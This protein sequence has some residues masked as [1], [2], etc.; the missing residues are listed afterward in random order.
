MKRLYPSARLFFWLATV[1]LMVGI[2][3]L[4]LLCA[5]I[6]LYWVAAV[7]WVCDDHRHKQLLFWS[8]ATFGVFAVSGICALWYYWG[9]LDYGLAGYV[10]LFGPFMAIFASVASALGYLSIR[11]RQQRNDKAPLIGPHT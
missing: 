5:A 9:K 11:G 4:P 6:P 1:A 3:W 7:L 10:I 8:A 2:F